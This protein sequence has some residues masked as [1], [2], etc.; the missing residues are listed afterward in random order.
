MSRELAHRVK[1]SFAVLQSILRSTL[2]ASRDPKHFAEAFSGRLHSLAA[3]QDI[4]TVN[5]WRGAELGALARGQL[6][7]Y[8]ESLPGKLTISGPPV[9]LPAEY[10]V[11]L[12]L[13]LHELATNAVKHGALS[14]PDGT[15]ALSWRIEPAAEQGRRLLVDWTEK[16]GADAAARGPDGF[17]ST[18]IEKS[19]PDAK[20]TRVFGP[21]GLVCKIEALLSRS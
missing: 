5:D 21:D 13:I 8:L 18:L 7:F 2:K 6:S 4:L 9:N 19:L 15:V 11:P 16:G 17:G 1:N 14:A 10:A 12:G 3:A 20:V